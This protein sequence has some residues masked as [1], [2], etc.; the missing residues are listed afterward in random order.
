MRR[1]GFFV[2]R[3]EGVA[4][5]QKLTRK[6]HD[7]RQARGIRLGVVRSVPGRQ[8]APTAP[9]LVPAAARIA[10]AIFAQHLVPPNRRAVGQ[11]VGIP[12]V[13]A[14]VIGDVGSAAAVLP[15]LLAPAM[16]IC[17]WHNDALSLAAGTVAN[18]CAAQG[19]SL[20]CGRHDTAGENSKRVTEPQLQMHGDGS[21][22]RDWRAVVPGKLAP[23]SAP[24][25]H[26]AVT[27]AMRAHAGHK[28]KGCS[29]LRRKCGAAC[30]R[31]LRAGD[32]V[33]QRS[34]EKQKIHCRRLGAH[35][36]C[37]YPPRSPRGDTACCRLALSTVA[38]CRAEHACE[39]AAAEPCLSSLASPQIL[40]SV[41]G[42]ADGTD[43]GRR[44]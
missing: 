8:L 21:S 39:E 28:P 35:I 41:C 4:P 1:G 25:A 30:P 20:H 19:L 38:N 31:P 36:C 27:G 18:R 24:Q 7:A 13:I 40:C 42:T 15:A 6:P 16:P 43:Q 26:M 29:Q 37:R 23:F 12:H 33:L 44:R 22:K 9:T 14:A 34:P 5:R 2:D 32:G 17:H 3:C 11:S 10:G